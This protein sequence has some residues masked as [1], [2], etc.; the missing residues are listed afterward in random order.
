MLPPAVRASL[1]PARPAELQAAME[2]AA[3]HLTDEQWRR[4][5]HL[6]VR[7]RS[8]SRADR[9]FLDDLMAEFAAEDAAGQ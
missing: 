2:L 4:N 3:H 7:S 1:D 8:R 6:F 9:Q 5:R